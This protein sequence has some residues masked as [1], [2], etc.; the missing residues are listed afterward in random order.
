MLLKPGRLL[1]TI[2]RDAT[3]A[4]QIVQKHAKR[5]NFR[6]AAF[7]RVC[8]RSQV[9]VIAL[10]A[11]TVCRI[12]LAAA[13]D[14]FVSFKLHAS[15]PIILVAGCSGNSVLLERTLSVGGGDDRLVQR[16]GHHP[17]SCRAR[18]QYQAERTKGRI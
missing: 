7:A 15:V 17:E 5:I 16:G 3:G 2:S 9:L 18:Y 12:W 6:S 4:W 1:K 14:R 11:A 13:C 10:F 8:L